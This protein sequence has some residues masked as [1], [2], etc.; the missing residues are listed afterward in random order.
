MKTKTRPW[1]SSYVFM[2]S[3]NKKY[4]FSIITFVFFV[5]IFTSLFGA[6]VMSHT[7]L[8]GCVG[9]NIQDEGCLLADT[10]WGHYITHSGIIKNL[11]LIPDSISWYALLTILFAYVLISYA[12]IAVIPAVSRV[13]RNNAILEPSS[14]ESDMSR[15]MIKRQRGDSSF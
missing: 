5:L 10:N 12:H 2:I 9:I 3:H 7:N 4:N 1:K 6:F 11:S 15:W 13:I 14:F 8:S